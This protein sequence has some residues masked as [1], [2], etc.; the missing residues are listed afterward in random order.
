MEKEESELPT[1]NFQRPTVEGEEAQPGKRL[2]TN[3]NLTAEA[4]RPQRRMP[5]RR[6]DQKEEILKS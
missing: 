1:S 4:R 2:I 3:A 5:R 6:E